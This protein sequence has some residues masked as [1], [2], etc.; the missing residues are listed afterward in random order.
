MLFLPRPLTRGRRTEAL[1]VGLSHAGTGRTLVQAL[2][3]RAQQDLARLGL[4]TVDLH[5]HE[6]LARRPR[7]RDILVIGRGAGEASR[8]QLG[9]RAMGGHRV[10][11]E[12]HN[13]L[14]HGAATPQC[15]RVNAFLLYLSTQEN[16]SAC[17][18]G[19]GTSP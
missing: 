14:R 15:V 18:G 6:L 11:E 10:R 8:R 1:E 17:L 16:S 4:P 9:P 19:Q 3:S 7:L 5:E 13:G 2:G 12:A